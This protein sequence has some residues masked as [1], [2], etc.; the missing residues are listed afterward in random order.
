MF[1]ERIW[2]IAN[3]FKLKSDFFGRPVAIF[4]CWIRH[5][6]SFH[7]CIVF[8]YSWSLKIYILSYTFYFKSPRIICAIFYCFPS[9][10]TISLHSLEAEKEISQFR[11]S[12][13]E[14]NDPNILCSLKNKLCNILY[15][16]NINCFFFVPVSSCI[17]N[18]TL[19]QYNRLQ[20]NR[21]SYFFQHFKF[22]VLTL[23][24]PI[25]IL[26]TLH[27]QISAFFVSI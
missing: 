26:S 2:L 11:V 4:C 19:F 25:R 1:V 10:H 15:L 6:F 27:C 22:T 5:V 13:S 24:Y 18:Q 8:R 12:E 16:K 7:F 17:V 3:V 23:N 14:M 9:A 20:K 21:H